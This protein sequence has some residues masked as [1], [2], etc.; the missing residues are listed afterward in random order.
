M[1]KYEKK[2]LPSHSTQNAMSDSSNWGKSRNDSARESIIASIMVLKRS[3][4][5][6]K[7]AILALRVETFLFNSRTLSSASSLFFLKK[8]NLRLEVLKMKNN[9]C[10]GAKGYHQPHN[11]HGDGANHAQSNRVWALQSCDDDRGCNTHPTNQSC[12]E[13]LVGQWA[14]YQLMT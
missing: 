4:L 3:Y 14:K 2:D 7:A 5:G 9:T 8:Q 1:V 13:G 11:H 12:I 6:F 10:K